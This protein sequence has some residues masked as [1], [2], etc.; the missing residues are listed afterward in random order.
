MIR[1]VLTHIGGVEIYGILSILI[2]FSFFIGMLVWVFRLRRPHLDTMA[3]LPL[4]EDTA[5][6]THDSNLCPETQP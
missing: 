2:F 4:Q 5:I 3:A 1:N 6:D